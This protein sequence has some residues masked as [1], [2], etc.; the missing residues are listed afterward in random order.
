MMTNTT[1][2][3]KE[4]TPEMFAALYAP[5]AFELLEGEHRGAHDLVME[6]LEPAEQELI[7]SAYRY[8]SNPHEYDI[9]PRIYASSARSIRT[10]REA[11]DN[12]RR[13][14][15]AEAELENALRQVRAL[16]TYYGNAAALLAS[17]Q[18]VPVY[19]LNRDSNRYGEKK[20][21]YTID[22]GFYDLTLE[23]IVIEQFHVEKYEGRDHRI[24]RAKFVEL[25]KATPGCRGYETNNGYRE[26]TKYES[27]TVTA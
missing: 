2:Q 12:V 16:K 9:A 7:R 3:P 6:S 4:Y 19:V 10:Q 27:A 25:V 26:N 18:K 21:T 17:T 5:A 15:K 14:E 8:G 11:A 13:M 24:A 23:R 20:V 1:P 22:R